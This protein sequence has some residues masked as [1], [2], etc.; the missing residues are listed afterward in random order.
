MTLHSLGIG[1]FDIKP[2]NAVVKW[3]TLLAKVVFK[4]GYTD[5]GFAAKVRAEIA[6]ERSIHGT[7]EYMPPET[8]KGWGGETEDERGTNALN[9]DVFGHAGVAWPILMGGDLPW[10]G[11][12]PPNQITPECWLEQLERVDTLMREYDESEVFSSTKQ[13][14]I[15]SLRPDPTQ[16]LTSAQFLK[17]LHFLIRSAKISSEIPRSPGSIELNKVPHYT[18]E[19]VA[20][21]ELEGKSAG[22]YRLF[23]E[24]SFTANGVVGLLY[25]DKSGILRTKLIEIDSENYPALMQQLGFLK[26]IGVLSPKDE[27]IPFKIDTHLD[28]DVPQKKTRPRRFTFKSPNFGRKDNAHIRQENT[29]S[30]SLLQRL[31]DFTRLKKD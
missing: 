30:M 7:P 14:L 17:G 31:F 26:E 4:A 27:V 2:E 16:R 8:T 15:E 24:N 9:A 10:A 18:T 28:A 13:L 21:A 6:K 29:K 22:T 12:C 3:K 19:D 23:K 1:H 20:R 5:F 25:I 11:L